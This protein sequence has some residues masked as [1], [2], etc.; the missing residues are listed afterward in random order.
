[1]SL[2]MSQSADNFFLSLTEPDKSCLLFL[3]DYML[4]FSDEITES[5]KNHTP[6]YYYRK[7]WMAFISYDTR[8]RIIYISFTDG[9]SMHH[10]KLLSE[11]RKRMKIFYVKAE[12]DIDIESLNKIMKM[13]VIL[14]KSE[15]AQKT[16]P[17]PAKRP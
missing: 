1:M 11:G 9:C 16:K 14:K 13:A 4:G 6:F 12:E 15:I 8:T 5:W 7:K 10:R 17:R 2:P 3:R